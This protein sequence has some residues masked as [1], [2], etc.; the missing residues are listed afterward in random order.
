MYLYSY[1]RRNMTKL[2]LNYLVQMSLIFS[3]I[4]VGHGPEALTEK[5]RASKLEL[6]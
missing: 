2:M 6:E 1:A 3:L 4:F 5:S